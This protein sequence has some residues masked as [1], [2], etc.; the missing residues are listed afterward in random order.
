VEINVKTL[1]GSQLDHAG[2]DLGRVA[3][4]YFFTENGKFAGIKSDQRKFYPATSVIVEA[5]RVR[6]GD[7]QPGRPEGE[8]WLGFSATSAKGSKLGSIDDI[9]F[10]PD[11]QVMTSLIVRQSLLFVP[12]HTRT[13]GYERIIDVR[14]RTVV[15]NCDTSISEKI[16]AAISGNGIDMPA[17]P[18]E[19]Y[20]P[21]REL[22]AQGR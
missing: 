1:L 11:L 9:R 3:A 21:T 2:K 19:C 12:L 14:K 10:D 4:V 5:G 8:D 7:D 18:K 20:E 22:E 17:S 15:F 16:P 13:F 6:I